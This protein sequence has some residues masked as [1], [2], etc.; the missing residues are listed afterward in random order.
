M[1]TVG[2]LPE[3][4]P[5]IGLSDIS[6][7]LDGSRQITDDR[8]EP[9]VNYFGFPL[10]SLYRNRDSPGHVPGDGSVLESSFDE[11]L[12][13]RLDVGTPVGVLSEFLHER[14]L[15]GGEFQS[16]LLGGP[17]LGG[18]PAAGTVGLEDVSGHEGGSAGVALVGT[19]VGGTAF[20]T[21]SLHIP[22]G[23]ELGA[24]RTVVLVLFDLVDVSVLLQAGEHVLGDLEVHGAVGLVVKGV[25][26]AQ[27]LDALLVDLVVALGDGL[28]GYAFLVRG[29]RD[30]GT[31][32]VRTAHHPDLVA[33]QDVIPAE[34]IRREERACHMAEMDGAVG[35]GP[36]DV[37]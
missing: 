35:V 3:G 16:E 33:E 10:F 9:H 24:F 22:V 23:K 17:D 13:E 37:D 4:L 18:G 29:N 20:G 19:D 27:S 15:E 25:L 11:V 8:I 5:V 21:D 34:Y 1:L 7:V 32:L 12:G 14:S 6:G 30:G 26:Y 28:R 2:I 36:G 31:V